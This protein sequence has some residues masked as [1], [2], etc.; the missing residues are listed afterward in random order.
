MPNPNLSWLYYKEYYKKLPIFAWDRPNPKDK[1]EIRELEVFFEGKHKPFKEAT[2]ISITSPAQ[3]NQPIAL[4]TAYPGLLIGTGYAHGSKILGETK[5]GFNFDYTSGMPIISGS[6]IKGTLRSIF[7]QFEQQEEEKWLLKSGEFTNE[8]KR[9]KAAFIARAFGF[10]D[11]NTTDDALAQMLS[12][13]IN[14]ILEKV[15]VLEMAVFE[16]LNVVESQKENKVIYYSSYK[17]DIFH[18]AFP[19]TGGKHGK[20]F[21]FDSITPHGAN[22]L[23]N[24]TPLLFLKVIPNVCFHFHF[25]LKCPIVEGIDSEKKKAVFEEILRT[26]GI[27]AK[28]NVGY[29]QFAKEKAINTVSPP[30]YEKT[31]N[32]KTDKPSYR[33]KEKMEVKS[34]YERFGD[35]PIPPKNETP[36]VEVKEEDNWVGMGDIKV[37]SIL[38]A[39]VLKEEA[40]LVRV[41]L[42]IKNDKVIL[43]FQGKVNGAKT[44]E[45]IVVEMGGSKAKNNLQITKIKK[46]A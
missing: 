28:T 19:V 43:S 34:K 22:L 24:P 5:L 13:D 9:T 10:I 36:S 7:P 31:Q 37:N 25:D 3:C 45:V 12:T 6:S 41:H 39:T 32:D 11:E 35:I 8:L 38:M 15:F 16:G 33:P 18:D 40:G 42:H 1:S 17:R 14:S 23:K 4:Y 20:I 26:L 21:D 27:G 44:C 46:K 30:V 29:G 2:I